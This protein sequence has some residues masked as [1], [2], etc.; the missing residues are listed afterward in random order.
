MEDDMTI[1]YQ[2]LEQFEDFTPSDKESGYKNVYRPAWH[3]EPFQFWFNPPFDET[4]IS[5]PTLSGTIVLLNDGNIMVENAINKLFF[6]LK[7][8]LGDSIKSFRLSIENLYH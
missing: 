3:P 5:V 1:I 4:G 2:F 6:N 8:C 7:D